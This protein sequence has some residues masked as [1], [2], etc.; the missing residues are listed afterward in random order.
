[1]NFYSKLHHLYIS[2]LITSTQK[3]VLLGHQIHKLKTPAILKIKQFSNANLEGFHTNTLENHLITAHKDIA[4][5]HS[6][7]FYLAVLF[8][9]GNGVHE[10]DFTTFDIR[11]GALFFLNPGQTHH[12]ELSADTKG[13][14]FFHTQDFYDIHF[15]Q[16]SIHDYPFYYS[17]HNSPCIYL[18]KEQ[19]NVATDLFAEILNE[20][21]KG[22]V[23]SQHKL[24]ALIDLVYIES[25]RIYLQNAQ[26]ETGN[27]NSY[28]SKF[29]QLEDAV[30]KHFREIKSPAEYADL[31]NISPKHLNRITQAVAG[32]STGDVVLERVLL[33]AKK[34][35][36]QQHLPLSEVAYTLGYDDYAYFSRIFKKK[37]GETPSAF[38][39]RYRK[40]L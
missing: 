28:Y 3:F 16:K 5:P 24:V 25:T 11:P 4:E 8:T 36:A 39:S 18:D 19:L 2:S 32:K 40:N 31:L 22:G 9:H 23:F 15:T 30:E 27:R 17:L 12:W 10:V 20:A 14:I 7:N 37:T 34:M 35:L 21:D 29:R 33:E 6:H 38:I 26:P 13:Y 1:M